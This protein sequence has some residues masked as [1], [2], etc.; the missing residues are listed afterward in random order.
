MIAL[1]LDRAPDLLLGIAAVL[2]AWSVFSRKRPLGMALLACAL[3]ATGKKL[4]DLVK[5]ATNGKPILPN[6]DDLL[7]AVIS[8]EHSTPPT[9]LETKN[10]MLPATLRVTYK[11]ENVQWQT[12]RLSEGKLIE[13]ESQEPK[14]TRSTTLRAST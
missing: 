1:V 11:L 12:I 14:A 9:Q 3:R 13:A 6:G 10:P 8:P 4:S 5:L 2:L 7:H